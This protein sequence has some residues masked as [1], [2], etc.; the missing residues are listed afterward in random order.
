MTDEPEEEHTY[1]EDCKTVDG[2]S[3]DEQY[4]AWKDNEL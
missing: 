1:C 3:C 4:Q 2:C